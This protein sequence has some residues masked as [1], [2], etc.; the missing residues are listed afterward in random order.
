MAPKDEDELADM[1]ATSLAIDGPSAIR[2]PRGAVADVQVQ[3]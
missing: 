3:S 1:M 2:Y